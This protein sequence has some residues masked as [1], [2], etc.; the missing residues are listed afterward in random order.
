SLS[1][2]GDGSPS[3]EYLGSTGVVNAPSHPVL[4]SGFEMAGRA[5]LPEK[6]RAALATLPAGP[7]E[8]RLALA[9]VLLSAGFF[10]V[11]APF[12]KVALPAIPAFMPIYQSAL[13]V[14]DLITAILL[15]GQFAIF[16]AWPLLLLAG[17]YLFSA[18]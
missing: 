7:R 9:V 16:G 10:I 15:F 1:W 6:G 17:A 5:A 12:A 8:R 18:A 14:C 2:I 4:E 11:A 3:P 13:V